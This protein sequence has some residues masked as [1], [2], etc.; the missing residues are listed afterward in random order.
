MGGD[1]ALHRLADD[2]RQNWHRVSR[3]AVFSL[4]PAIE[5]PRALGL[6]G[7]AQKPPTCQSV[8]RSASSSEVS[9]GQKYASP[10]GAE[11]PVYALQPSLM[12]RAM[13]ATPAA[14][15]RTVSPQ[16]TNTVPDGH[17][18]H[19]LLGKLSFELGSSDTP[20]SPSSQTSFGR[21]KASPVWANRQAA[22]SVKTFFG[23]GIT[24]DSPNE[25]PIATTPP[26]KQSITRPKPDAKFNVGR[27]T[28]ELPPP[29]PPKSPRHNAHPRPAQSPKSPTRHG[30]AQLVRPPVAGAPKEQSYDVRPTPDPKSP[31]G[32]FDL[33]VP[34]LAQSVT[35][36]LVRPVFI[37]NPSSRTPP[38]SMG[39][40]SD[41]MQTHL[42][43]VTDSRVDSAVARPIAATIS[44]AGRSSP[45]SVDSSK[46]TF[47]LSP[48]SKLSNPSDNNN[49]FI[50]PSARPVIEHISTTKDVVR[51]DAGDRKPQQQ[52]QPSTGTFRSILTP[53]SA[54]QSPSV[55]TPSTN[56]L[57]VHSDSSAT[58][59]NEPSSLPPAPPSKDDT[60]K[61]ST[62][63]GSTKA[64]QSAKIATIQRFASLAQSQRDGGKQSDLPL[65]RKP[66]N[67]TIQARP[68]SPQNPKRSHESPAVVDQ[69]Q[70]YQRTVT[71][72]P[73]PTQRPVTPVQLSPAPSREAIRQMRARA[74]VSSQP[75]ARPLRQLVRPTSPQDQPRPSQT[76]RSVP[77]PRSP[78]ELESLVPG[79]M[80]RRQ[81]TQP[82]S[83]PQISKSFTP[84]PE[85]ADRAG[86]QPSQ[87]GVQPSQSDA[88][89]VSE[90]KP[91]RT[92]PPAPEAHTK[93][94]PDSASTRTLA[95]KAAAPSEKSTSTLRP[96]PQEDTATM[97]A[98]IQELG[99]QSEALHTRYALLRSD[100]QKLSTRIV[101]SLKENKSD[102]DYM[103]TLLDQHLSL[104]TISS[105]MDICFAKLK[106]LDC[107]KEEAITALVAHVEAQQ[108][109]VPVS[110]K[111]TDRST[112]TVPEPPA[113]TLKLDV[114][115]VQKLVL[116]KLQPDSAQDVSTQDS[117]QRDDE[118]DTG[119]LSVTTT[120]DAPNASNDHI[121]HAQ[122][123]TVSHTTRTSHL[124][125]KEPKRNSTIRVTGETAA[126][127][128]S[129][130]AEEANRNSNLEN[131]MP[132]SN[133]LELGPLP[134]MD[135]KFDLKLG[136]MMLEVDIPTSPFRLMGSSLWDRSPETEKSEPP[137]WNAS[138]GSPGGSSNTTLNR[139]TSWTVSS[140]HGPGSAA[141]SAVGSITDSSSLSRD[142]PE[143]NT[144]GNGRDHA[145]RSQSPTN[146]IAPGAKSPALLDDDLLDYYAQQRNGSGSSIVSNT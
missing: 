32:S 12:P 141:S 89:I 128:L 59:L 131:L 10:A 43:P 80:L 28:D 145:I 65:R 146:G 21:A 14:D 40:A 102:G 115:T 120:A 98:R 55:Q 35:R 77:R 100:R 41:M 27:A 103:N 72:R 106:A 67:P 56:I 49:T 96:S 133:E 57:G 58:A 88:N 113:Q 1:E 37:E 9:I 18:R 45:A 75:T 16:I 85:P 122:T 76:S 79:T 69:P 17:Q 105:S 134:I 116:P 5:P 84:A 82:D 2:H 3:A 25:E 142:E 114:P 13:P 71:P 93:S 101:S 144:P 140:A 126:R 4:W 20:V 66:I 109:K 46:P 42:P 119:A 125:P 26:A 121:P 6:V 30:T 11:I 108:Q 111:M 81:K 7:A 132:Q 117:N 129:I 63:Q 124:K 31:R 36:G 8:T 104:N 29:P 53:N 95:S 68:S 87:Q 54:S 51:S 136:G 110:A 139:R 19:G 73:D 99:Q 92:F 38:S 123:D 138:N 50:S 23:L 78:D 60:A 62:K 33:G 83:P 112:N 74:Q 90:E 94:G 22:S 127:V 61:S 97:V 70:Q 48:I 24:L 52:P 44:K 64:T 130:T 47:P 107:R 91:M 86:T 15:A 34:V 143:L 137:P 135:N 39:S 118:E